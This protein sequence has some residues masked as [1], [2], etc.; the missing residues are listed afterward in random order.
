MHTKINNI[1][2]MKGNEGDEIIGKLFES[3]LQKYQ[4]GLEESIKGSKFVFD[5]GHLLH[6]K[7]LKVSL[8]RT[9][10]CIDFLLNGEKVIKQL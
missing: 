9:G 3:F 1:E 2:I 4:K 6:Y 10:S 5:T 7:F 8:N